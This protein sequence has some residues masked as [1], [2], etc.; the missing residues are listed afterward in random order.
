MQSSGSAIQV[1]DYN[2]KSGHDSSSNS[3]ISIPP[4][5]HFSV[6]NPAHELAVGDFDGDGVQDIFLATGS[7][8]YFSPGGKAGW[9]YLNGGKTDNV[10][11]LLFGDFDGDGR[12][13]VVGINAGNLM[14]SWGGISDW[15]VLSSLPPG[16]SVGDLAVGDFDGDGRSDIFYADGK[17]WYVSSGGSGPFTSAVNTSSFRVADLRFGHFSICGSKKET[18]VFGIVSGKWQVSCGARSHWRPLPVSLTNSLSGLVVADFDGD[19]NADIATSANSN[20]QFSRDAAAGWTVRSP[21]PV[22]LSSAAA[23][24]FFDSTPGADV[25]LWGD[26][27]STE[28]LSIASGGNPSTIQRWSIEEMR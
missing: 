1:W 9:R 22:P 2:G 19:G 16:A 13:D 7:G 21:A 5:N 4:G 10:K 8:W 14:V 11:N 27:S 25:L 23:I 12:T 26:P 18:D 24:G 3:E 15:E 28:T 17:N 20:W 6:P